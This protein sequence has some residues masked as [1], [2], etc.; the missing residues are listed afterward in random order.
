MRATPG[1]CGRASEDLSFETALQELTGKNSME[2]ALL[3][4][5]RVM[6][7]HTVK[8]ANEY[9]GCNIVET[10]SDATDYKLQQQVESISKLSPNRK[11][12]IQRAL[13]DLGVVMR[14][15]VE[16][17]LENR[18]IKWTSKPQLQI[19]RALKLT[20]EDALQGSFFN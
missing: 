20:F 7:V 10:D 8:R 17:I 13:A 1:Q 6:G 12:E 9:M 16:A 15:K 14:T 5:E 4:M 19:D 2:T 18:L 11:S 3:F